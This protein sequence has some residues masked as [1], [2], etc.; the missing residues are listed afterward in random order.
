MADRIN[1]G[2]KGA[3]PNALLSVQ[4][5]INCGNAGSCHGGWDT[6]VY[7]YAKNS[8]I[9]DETCNNYQVCLLMKFTNCHRLSIKNALT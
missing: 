3:W 4:N 6:G 5:V 1:I 7:E 9:P 8:G 2:R